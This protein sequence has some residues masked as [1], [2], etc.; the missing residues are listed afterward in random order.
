MVIS[1]AFSSPSLSTAVGKIERAEGRVS[2]IK[3]GNFRGI[4]YR[5]VNGKIEVGDVVR[6][7]RK[8]YAEILFIDKSRVHLEE[9]SRLIVEKFIPGKIVDIK[10][11]SGK[12]IYRISKVTKGSYRI[13]TPTALIGVKGTVLATIVNNGISTIIVKRGTVEVFNP[14]FPQNRVFL[15]S[16]MATVV[17]PGAPPSKPVLVTEQLV[18]KLFEAKAQPDSETLLQKPEDSRQP[19]LNTA[20][21]HTVEH[22]ETVSEEI[23]EKI[24]TATEAPEETYPTEESQEESS[25]E[26]I[27]SLEIVNKAV[28]LNVYIPQTDT[29][30]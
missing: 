26:A 30:R 9:R 10:S 24:E 20:K 28:K 27:S 5:K 23:S 17:K 25:T 29:P 12:V 8:S 4:N 13:K 6:T 2:I 11:P 14:E 16:R 7:K 15:R 19:I 22:Q 21:F 1:L 3:K 18:S